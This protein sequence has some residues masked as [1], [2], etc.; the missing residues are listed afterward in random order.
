MRLMLAALLSLPLVFAVAPQA[1]ETAAADVLNLYRVVGRSWTVRT[2]TWQRGGAPVREYRRYE[3]TAANDD[4]CTLKTIGLDKDGFESGGDQARD[5]RFDEELRAASRP[6]K[7]AAQSRVTAAGI[8]FACSLSETTTT[9]SHDQVWRSTRFPALIVRQRVVR[10]DYVQLTDL[11][12]FN[13]GGADPWTLYRM[14][15]RKWVYKVIEGSGE[16]AKTTFLVNEVVESS[17]EGAKVKVLWLDKSRKPVEGDLGDTKTIDFETATPWKQPEKAKDQDVI[18]GTI[19]VGRIKWT[20]I[21]IRGSDKSEF[22]S[23]H[24]PGLLLKRTAKGGEQILEEFYTGHDEQ[25][26][27]RV[28][29]NRVMT[30]NSYRFGGRRGGDSTSYQLLEVTEVNDKAVKFRNASLDAD[31]RQM[32]AQESNMTITPWV[33]YPHVGNEPVEERI[34][35]VAGVFQCLKDSREGKGNSYSTWRHHG[36][37]IRMVNDGE[38]YTM[39]QEVTELKLE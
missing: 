39:R 37:N 24:W 23:R 33:P 20:S 35:T 38:G 3:V 9:T 28:V 30:R 14:V 15:G 19:N 13:E 34:F 1:Q 25:K 6:A 16:S 2:I 12:A 27:Y 4:F 18:E 5:L 22:Y 32:W 7:D 8:S 21:E 10:Q 11:V 36:V 29:G 17:A 31:M 26:Q